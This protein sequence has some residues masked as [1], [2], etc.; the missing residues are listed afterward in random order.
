M[1]R[2]SSRSWIAASALLLS[3]AAE[4][5]AAT[6]EIRGDVIGEIRHTR[7]RDTDNLYGL[8]RNV[9]LGI[10]ETLVANPHIDDL[11]M[12]GDGTKLTLPT[13]YILPPVRE[14]IVVNLPE[15]RLYFFKGNTVYTYPVGIGKEGFGSPVGQSR[16][17][18]M[19]KDP[20][21]IVP[22]SIRAEKP[23]LPARV[24]PGPDNPLG[25]YA[26][27]TGWNSVVIHGTN[28]PNGVGLRSSHGCMRM[29]PEDIEELFSMV[30]VG[31]K[32]TFLD[33]PYKLGWRGREL[34]LEV[35][36]TQDQLD[37]IVQQATVD[38]PD[39]PE[40]RAAVAAEAGK[41]GVEIDWY[42]VD[43]A[44][45]ERNSLP[46]VIAAKPSLPQG[47]LGTLRVAPGAESATPASEGPAAE[48]DALIDAPEVIYVP[49]YP[50]EI[51]SQSTTPEPPYGDPGV[52]R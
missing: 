21:W 38:N 48:I 33:M 10:V 31:T 7:T 4:T 24:E 42:A 2:S 49:G 27:N 30:K 26:M 28:T 47:T 19:R 36:P 23:E 17:V 35:T 9:N 39:M 34:F 18:R 41:H 14:G 15:L 37:T 52:V 5:P 25:A 29:Y 16:I 43:T 1:R 50:E 32:V 44:I 8:A 22:A 11:W 20:V 51:P 6:Y 3:T 45:K 12:P 46:L 13:E 40:V